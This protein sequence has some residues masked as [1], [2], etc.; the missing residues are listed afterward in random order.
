MPRNNPRTKAKQPPPRRHTP[1][2]GADPTPTHPACSTVTRRRPPRN[3]FAQNEKKSKG[4]RNQPVTAERSVGGA[5]PGY[6]PTS[7]YLPRRRERPRNGAP[8]WRGWWSAV[9]I[10][11]AFFFVLLR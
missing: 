1:T 8:P 6:T 2:P 9:Y 3:L 5:A 11:L 10:T 4:K 7:L